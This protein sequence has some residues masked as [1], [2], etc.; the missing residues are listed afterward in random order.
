M[1]RIFGFVGLNNKETLKKMAYPLKTS[2]IYS[3]YYVDDYFGFGVISYNKDN[4]IVSDEKEEIWVILD[5]EIYNNRFLIDSLEKKGHHFLTYS[6]AEIIAH[7]FKEERRNNIGKLRGK[8]AAAIFNVNKKLLFLTRDR[9]GESPLYYTFHDNS[10]F[11]SSEIK[12][13]LNAHNIARKINYCALNYYLSL[14]HIP[15]PYTMFKDIYKIPPANILIYSHSGKSSIHKYWDLN[16]N[17]INIS[18]EKFLIKQI[19]HKLKENVEI[20]LK[21]SKDMGVLLSGG[22]DSSSIAALLIKYSEHSIKPFSVIYDI[23]FYNELNFI[24]KICN[25]LNIESDVHIIQSN[26][27]NKEL[28]QKLVW[29]FDEPIA[30]SSIIPS[31]IAFAFSSDHVPT[32]FTGDG[33]DEAFLGYSPVYWKEPKLLKY[34]SRIPS[35]LKKITIKLT[36]PIIKIFF[37]LS[38]LKTYDERKNAIIDDFLE[39]KSLT[40]PDPEIRFAASALAR[41]FSPEQIKKLSLIKTSSHIYKNAYDLTK[42]IFKKTDNINFKNLKKNYVFIKLN[43]PADTNKTERTSSIFPIKVRSPFLDHELFDFSVSIPMYYKIRNGFT[44]YILR[45]VLLKYK[46]LPKEI[47]LSKQKRGFECPIEYWLKKDL[48]GLMQEKLLEDKSLI[49][50]H[51]NKNYIKKITSKIDRYNAFKIWNLLIL[52]IWCDVFNLY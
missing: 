23:P 44:K 37:D 4:K 29:M 42:E 35:I 13:I 43:L 21:G 10:L 47:I 27:I 2:G 1:T 52:S 39:R 3:N 33:G 50:S 18:N 9:F 7:L 36:I 48:K 17:P 26:D 12:S 19:Y 41:F 46:M 32:I 51:F 25:Y 8:F 28:I 38:G 24:E 6:D 30:N 31:Y 14:G 34:Y 15:A 45:K 20:R 16:P 22:I 5:G 40:D 49:T 11:F